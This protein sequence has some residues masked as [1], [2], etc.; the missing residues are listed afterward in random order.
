M[1]L[2]KQVIAYFKTTV[3]DEYILSLEAWKEGALTIYKLADIL[4]ELE[5]QI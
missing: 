3:N 2:W 5:E 1:H 4:H